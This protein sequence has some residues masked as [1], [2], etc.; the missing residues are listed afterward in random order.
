MGHGSQLWSSNPY[1]NMAISSVDSTDVLGS[2]ASCFTAH[3]GSPVNETLVCSILRLIC[4]I[5]MALSQRRHNGDARSVPSDVRAHRAPAQ[6]RSCTF[7]YAKQRSWPWPVGTNRS[8][9]GI[10]RSHH[11]VM[12]ITACTW[13][14]YRV[15]VLSDPQLPLKQNME[16]DTESPCSCHRVLCHLAVIAHHLLPERTPRRIVTK[17]PRI[18][19]KW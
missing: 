19:G 4:G 12:R 5:C 6:L 7:S 10:L 15:M 13:H 1:E 11:S 18:V 16:Q 3:A 9:G 8:C 14:L 2:H 17:S